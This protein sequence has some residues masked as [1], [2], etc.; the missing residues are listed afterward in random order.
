MEAEEAG[1]GRFGN[2]LAGGACWRLTNEDMAKL[3]DDE[4]WAERSP[5][6]NPEEGGENWLNRRI[7]VLDNAS[8][9]CLNRASNGTGKAMRRR[10]E[11]R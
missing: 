9:N 8:T 4:T 5:K 1:A 2:V 7:R 11:G 10:E 6:K 3:S